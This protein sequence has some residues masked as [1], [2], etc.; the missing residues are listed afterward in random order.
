MAF[1]R[2]TEVAVMMRSDVGV[3]R[4]LARDTATPR[5]LERFTVVTC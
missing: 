3:T 2:F 5:G 4:F 1:L